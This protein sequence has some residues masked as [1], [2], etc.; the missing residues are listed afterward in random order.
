MPCGL[1]GWG[2]FSPLEA[3]LASVT[4]SDTACSLQSA[5]CCLLSGAVARDRRAG[6]RCVRVLWVAGEG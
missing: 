2:C 5:I 3:T 4:L 1:V 6:L